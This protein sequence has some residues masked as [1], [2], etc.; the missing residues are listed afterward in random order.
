MEFTL[1]YQFF[2][3]HIQTTPFR[4][5]VEPNFEAHTVTA[6]LL[7]TP[8]RVVQYVCNGGCDITFKLCMAGVVLATAT[9]DVGQ[10][11]RVSEERVY[12]LVCRLL[13]YSCH[14]QTYIRESLLI[15]HV[16]RQPSTQ[17][18]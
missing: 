13:S 9:V 6:R 5:L 10:C 18:L 14:F 4:T 8:E 12:V 17:N 15:L 11:L 2:G 7:A 16:V 1:E 3:E